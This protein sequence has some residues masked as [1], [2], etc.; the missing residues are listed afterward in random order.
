MEHINPGYSFT[1]RLKLDNR[2]GT[3]AKALTTIGE[4]GGAL[5]AIDL[6]S[7]N[8]TH[9]V[10]DLNIESRDEPHS[11]LIVEALRKTPGIEVIQ[12]SDRIFLLH[13]GGKIEVSSKVTIKTR[14][15][16]S[17]VYTPGVAK[18]SAAIAQD[19]SKAYTLTIKKNTV[20]VVSDGTAV[21][22]LGD[23]GP[24][25]AL[26]VM[27]GKAMLFKEFGGV[28]AW[29]IVLNTKDPDEIVATVSHLSPGF[30]GIN[31]EDIS[32]P[33]CFKI[34]EDLRNRLDIPVFHDDQHGTAVVVLA[35]VMNGLKVVQK[36]LGEIKIV[37]NGAGAAG[38]AVSKI[39]LNAGG[40]NLILCDRKGAIYLGREEDM[41]PYKEE[42]A[43]ITNPKSEKGS[44]REVL[45]GADLIIGLSAPRLLTADDIQTMNS[46]SI[47]FA[48]AN[49]EPE[50]RRDEAL[51]YARIYASGRSDT[52]NQ[53]NNVLAFPGIF[54]GALDVRARSI[55]EEMKL[56]AAHALS[57]VIPD[58]ELSEEYI[59]PSVF[60]KEVVKRV[61]EAVAEAARRTGVARKF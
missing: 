9:K 14:D 19:K 47:V 22:G 59:I 43:K 20:A 3:L 27:E 23:I 21:L 42:M 54:R 8:K 56:A 38:I 28:D 26:P 32:A 10:R 13:L 41:N 53:I 50:I 18:V 30:G 33:R 58:D 24:E 31:L 45:G 52:P 55:N 4:L 2:P 51:R 15:D 37:V 25:A 46:D 29:P 39:L 44:L 48:M 35:G 36:K 61:S 7:G 34:E 16:L 17:M 40:K 1:V 11:F 60:N 57:S 12:V 6:V 49:P 5:G